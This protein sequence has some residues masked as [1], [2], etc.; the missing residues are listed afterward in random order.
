VRSLCFP[1]PLSDYCGPW[2]QRYSTFSTFSWS[3]HAYQH[4]SIPLYRVL[5]YSVYSVYSMLQYSGWQQNKGLQPCTPHKK[6]R[7]ELI[8]SD[9]FFVPRNVNAVSFCNLS[10]LYVSIFA[11]SFAHK[12]IDLHL[13]ISTCKMNISLGIGG[14]FVHLALGYLLGLY[15]RWWIFIFWKLTFALIFVGF[16]LLLKCSAALFTQFSLRNAYC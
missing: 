3:L 12:V 5:Q 15:M 10:G 2:L 7:K 1:S 16:L 14:N 4:T 9:S 11:N 13:Y 8:F 6:F